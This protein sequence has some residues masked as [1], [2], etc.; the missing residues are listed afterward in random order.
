MKHI[1]SDYDI[2]DTDFNNYRG[3]PSIRNHNFWRVKYR[4]IPITKVISKCE[5]FRATVLLI[6]ISCNR[7]IYLKLTFSVG[8]FTSALREFFL[9]IKKEAFPGSARDL[10]AALNNIF[11]YQPEW[12]IGPY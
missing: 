3:E 2:Y 4:T 5:V 8:A 1:D 10:Q 12:N 11:H 6:N 7:S 9:A